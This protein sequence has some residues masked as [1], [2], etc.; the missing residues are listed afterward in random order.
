MNTK[1]ITSIAVLIAA[2][3]AG[4]APLPG[5]GGGD[6]EPIPVILI[7]FDALRPDHTG[8]DG[9]RRNTTPTLNRLARDGVVFDQA[10]AQAAFTLPSMATLFTGL[11]P[12]HHGVRRHLDHQGR[13][14]RLAPERTTLAE[15]LN[16]RGYAT[17]AVVSNS[18]FQLD[19]GFD[20]GFDHFNAGR[21]RDAG[22]TTDAA[23]AW[24]KARPKDRPFFL[25]IHYIDPHWPYDAPNE[26]AR[27]FSHD[28]RGEYAAALRAFERGRLSPGRLYFENPFS[29]DGV[30]RAVAEYDNE[31][32]YA[33][34]ELSRLIRYLKKE[35]LYEKALIVAVSDHGESLGEHGLHFAHSFNLYEPV[36]RVLFVVKPPGAGGDGRRDGDRDGGSG[37]RT[38]GHRSG[39]TVDFGSWTQHRSRRSPPDRRARASSRPRPPP[40]TH[41]WACR[42]IR[43][44]RART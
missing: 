3:A 27:P 40:C 26:Y 33:D 6:P 35:G 16:A 9:Y 18:L 11:H 38:R 5:C 1:R 15:T 10:S 36:Q 7:V 20:Q 13:A 44:G 43:G 8:L 41:S 24:L 12:Y 29:P 25:W 32:A 2:L 17:A 39:R 19:T 28:D 30:Q 21:R 22:P 42:G 4:L 14:D 37:S 23:L 34:R 31:I